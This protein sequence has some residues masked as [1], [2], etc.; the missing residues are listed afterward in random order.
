MILLIY[1]KEDLDS[2][3]NLFQDQS[4]FR[5]GSLDVSFF[6]FSLPLLP[7]RVAFA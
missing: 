2:L 5:S 6:F 4:V 7:F 3:K 1:P